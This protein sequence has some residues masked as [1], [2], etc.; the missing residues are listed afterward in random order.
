MKISPIREN[1]KVTYKNPPYEFFEAVGGVDGMKD[2][3][4]S[5]Y[6]KIYES[7]IAHFFPQDEEEFAKVKEKNTLFFIAI[8]GGPKL[9]EGASDKNLNEYMIEFHKN[10]SIDEKARIE[11]LGTMMETLE[12]LDIPKE[13]KQAFWDYV[14][15]F[16]KLMVNR[17]SELYKYV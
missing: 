11:W 8:C 3:M 14:D 2:F 16:S 13:L 12:E 15:N 5:F 9:Y 10:F 17:S 1:E 6:D 4:Y 7:E